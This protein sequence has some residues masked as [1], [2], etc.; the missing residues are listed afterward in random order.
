[1]RE[2]VSQ[3]HG[4]PDASPVRYSD[5]DRAQFDAPLCRHC[6]TRS[7]AHWA[8]AG[9]GMWT[10]ICVCPND[11]SRIQVDPPSAVTGQG[12]DDA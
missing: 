10:V 12:F 4:N 1:M 7:E 9:D 2:P 8:A 11:G 6:G 3:T 5:A